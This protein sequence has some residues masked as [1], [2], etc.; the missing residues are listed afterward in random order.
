[1]NYSKLLGWDSAVYLAN[2]RS[3]ISDSNFSEDFRFP[4][5]ELMISV[6][7]LVFGES[8]LII[9]LLMIIFSTLALFGFYLVSKEFMKTEFALL[10]TIFLSLTYVFLYWSHRI[11][12]DIPALCMVLFAIYFSFKYINGK[13]YSKKKIKSFDKYIYFV[14][15]LTGLIFLIRYPSVLFIIPIL[16]FLLKKDLKG[17]AKLS[18]AG[19]V[20]VLPWFVYNFVKYGN[21]LWSLIQQFQRFLEYTSPEPMS[22]LILFFI[23]NVSFIGL[24]F[25]FGYSKKKNY[26]I[27]FMILLINSAYYL[28]LVNLKLERYLLMIMPFFLIICFVGAEN[29]FKKVKMK[30]FFLASLILLI[31][32]LSIVSFSKTI[33]QT[34]L[35]NTSPLIPAV[36]Y[37]KNIPSDKTIVSNYFPLFGY[38][39]NHKISSLWSDNLL[40]FTEYDYFIY[41]YE[42]GK[43]SDF[44]VYNITKIESYDDGYYFLDIYEFDK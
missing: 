20:V 36:E 5:L 39:G 1:M 27:V 19:M 41:F 25:F 13:V 28:F 23:W 2:A 16:L 37:V 8:V 7:W 33:L 6:V 3:H 4:L 18:L 21:P 15:V 43:N 42:R 24:L 10:A 17:L 30:N 31:I 9:K 40:H 14:G 12:T 22:I 35:E 38:Y 34:H 29:I 26:W 11:Y 32:I 44:S